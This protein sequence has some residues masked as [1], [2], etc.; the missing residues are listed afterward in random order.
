MVTQ[1]TPTLTSAEQR[2]A[3]A[4]T[5]QTARANRTIA[6]RNARRNKY[7]PQPFNAETLLADLRNERAAQ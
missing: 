7:A 3:T 4:H 5:R 2:H 1:A 6:R